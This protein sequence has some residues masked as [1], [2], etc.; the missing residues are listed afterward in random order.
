MVHEGEKR[1]KLLPRGDLFIIAKVCPT[2]IHVKLMVRMPLIEPMAPF[3]TLVDKSVLVF[4]V[5][6][7]QMKILA[8]RLPINK[9]RES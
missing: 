5:M 3:G 6:E 2:I 7:K 1:I 4:R 9:K 8:K